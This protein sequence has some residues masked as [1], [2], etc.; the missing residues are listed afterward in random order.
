MKII[1]SLTFLF[2]CSFLKG[3][4]INSSK[5]IIQAAT[6][7]SEEEFFVDIFRNQDEIK[8]LYKIKDSVSSKL[9]YDTNFINYSK[10][11]TSIINL[12]PANDS[13]AIY[14]PQLDS[15]YNLYTIFSRDSLQFRREKKRF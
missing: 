9:S 2:F 10:I 4:K 5:I 8:V 13:L 14:L 1:L 15:I 12:N 11:L 6:S 7:V 3:Q